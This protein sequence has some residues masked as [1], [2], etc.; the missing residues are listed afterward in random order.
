[1]ELSGPI[2]RSLANFCIKLEE[3]ALLFFV[4]QRSWTHSFVFLFFIPKLSWIIFKKPCLLVTT[5]VV[6]VSVS[7]ALSRRI[8]KR[9]CP[10]E[11][12]TSICGF[13]K[14]EALSNVSAGFTA[15]RSYCYAPQRVYR[16]IC[17]CTLSD[18]FVPQKVDVRKSAENTM[19]LGAG[20]FH[21]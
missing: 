16:L 15:H 21:A 19:G 6:N 20:S 5:E 10:V 4:D 11:I 14:I 17:S 9:Y 13:L 12:H 7:H 2:L 1:M 3:G 18:S 8:V